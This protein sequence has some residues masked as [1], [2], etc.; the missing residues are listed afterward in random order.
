[1]QPGYFLPALLVNRLRLRLL[2]L[3]S[4]GDRAA[5]VRQ[6]LG[7]SRM[8]LRVPAGGEQRLF[9]HLQLR[10]QGATLTF[11]RLQQRAELLDQP[12]ARG[13]FAAQRAITVGVRHGCAG[14]AR[15]V[16]CGRCG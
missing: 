2:C 8:L 11:P 12:V 14:C 13:E 3:H 7:V 6:I 15:A 1:M 4:G 10:E 9:D 16:G 5:L